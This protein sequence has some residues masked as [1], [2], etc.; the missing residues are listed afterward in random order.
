MASRMPTP[1]Q[2]LGPHPLCEW[3]IFLFGRSRTQLHSCRAGTGS[4]ILFFPLLWS[5]RTP[6]SGEF[7]FSER[8]RS[9]RDTNPFLDGN[10][11]TRMYFL[12]DILKTIINS[13]S[14]DMM[15]KTRMSPFSWGHDK[16]M[17]LLHC[18]PCQAKKHFKQDKYYNGPRGCTF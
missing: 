3:N 12:Q 5:S 16:N 9:C 15:P 4:N 6:Q 18:R 11:K 7:H 10:L 17:N 1:A 13:F 8:L 14:Y 2:T